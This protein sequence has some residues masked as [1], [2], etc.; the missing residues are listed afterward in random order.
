VHIVD[1]LIYERAPRL[2]SSGFWWALK[3]VLYSILGYGRAVNLSDSIASLGG[4]EALD[5][6]S[7]HLSLKVEAK[8]L[9]RLPKSGRCVVVCNHPTGIADGIAVFDAIRRV[10]KDAIF[11]ANADA[12][13]VCPR[14]SETLIPVEWVESKRTREKARATLMAAKQAFEEE[15]CIVVFPSGR[16][17]VRGKD[18]QLCDPPWM[19]TAI[20]LAQKNAAPII[21]I[22]ISGPN[23]FLFHF[24]AHFS[25]E[26]RDITLFHEF[27]NKAETRFDLTVGIPILPQDVDG[28]TND[29]TL[30]IKAYVER[31]L[32]TQPDLSFSS[33]NSAP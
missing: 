30:R 29:L 33:Y 1:E 23:S 7:E 15:R 17:A 16:L 22:H 8:H 11:F 18:G 20:S 2:I 32:A 13:R 24:F 31:S 6:V 27:L 5:Y 12:L 9:D 28:E 21:P 3:P 14:F 26:M 19:S 25:Q 10:R 4:H